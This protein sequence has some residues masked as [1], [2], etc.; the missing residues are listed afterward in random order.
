MPR[1]SSFGILWA[2]VL[3]WGPHNYVKL[4][5]TEEEIPQLWREYYHLCG[6]YYP[7]KMLKL[8]DLSARLCLRAAWTTS[9]EDAM[10]GINTIRHLDD[11]ATKENNSLNESSIL[12]ARLYKM[13]CLS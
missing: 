9:P 3:I 7:L 10:S 13:S 6:D 11:G 1:L 12:W 4:G 2:R 5:D 8:T